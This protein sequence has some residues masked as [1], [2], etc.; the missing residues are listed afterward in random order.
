MLLASNERRGRRQNKHGQASSRSGAGG[1]PSAVLAVSGSFRPARRTP[2]PRLS[3]DVADTDVLAGLPDAPKAKA[4][5]Q[6]SRFGLMPGA[7]GVF[8]G[9][10]RPL[11]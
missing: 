10:R 7:F 2:G 6:H 11:R 5:V 9:R 8:A 3:G 1:L 4:C